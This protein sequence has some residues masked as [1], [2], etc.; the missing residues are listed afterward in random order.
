LTNLKKELFGI[1]LSGGKSK[2]MGYDKSNIMFKEKSIFDLILSKVSDQVDSFIINSNNPGIFKEKINK[3]LEVVSDCVP[4]YLGPLAG[5]LTGLK[6]VSTQKQ[7]YS[8]LATFP[9]DSPFFPDNYIELMLEKSKG[10][11]IIMAKCR[12]R[13]HPV[14]SLWRVDLE[15]KLH[16]SLYS[17]IRKIEDF[18]KKCN[19]R[20]VNFD[21]IGY[22][23]FFNINNESDLQIANSIFSELEINK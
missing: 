13:I 17:G 12:S 1:I 15:Q 20:L 19:T 10:H 9:I 7:N 14:F 23:P 21:Y 5:V 2:R 4:G 11:E 3:N 6:W 16:D 22:D 8:W 18:T